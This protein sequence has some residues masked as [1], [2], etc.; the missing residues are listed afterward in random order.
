[1]VHLFTQSYFLLCLIP[2]IHQK[3]SSFV[4]SIVQI[5]MYTV[6]H[7]VLTIT[8]VYQNPIFY[9]F[10]IFIH[11]TRIFDTGHLHIQA[12]YF[13]FYEFCNLALFSAHIDFNH[14]LRYMSSCQ[15]NPIIQSINSL[16]LLT[17]HT[18]N[19]L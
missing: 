14:Y 13:L 11:I 12:L 15:A 7:I 2:F 1:M 6:S 9:I 4:N 10:I 3:M 18:Q 5:Y 8:S 16:R 17:W 19:V